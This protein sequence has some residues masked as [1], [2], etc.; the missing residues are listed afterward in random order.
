MAFWNRIVDWFRDLSERERL[1]KEFNESARYAF[2]SL[3][4][5][6]L[7]NAMTKAGDPNYRHECSNL[8]LRS[9]FCIRATSGRSLSKDE[10][11]YIGTVIL[12]NQPLVRRLFVLGWDTL[13][14]ED[15]VG[16]KSVKWPIKNFTN[17]GYFL[18]GGMGNGPF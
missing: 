8:F 2:S 17:I 13:I 7:L 1:L 15:I 11:L 4:V 18:N 3:E 10:M 16:N 12:T 5:S 9:G 6:T 14:I